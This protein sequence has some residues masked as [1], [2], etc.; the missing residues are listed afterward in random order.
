MKPRR[1]E[2][3]VQAVVVDLVQERPQ[4]E[5]HPLQVVVLV[6]WTS[7]ICLKRRKNKS[8]SENGNYQSPMN[9]SQN[10]KTESTR[11]KASMLALTVLLKVSYQLQKTWKLIL[12]TR[13]TLMN[14]VKFHLSA[15]AVIRLL[16]FRF[17]IKMICWNT[18]M[19]LSF[20]L[21]SWMILKISSPKKPSSLLS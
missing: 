6:T 12:K 3:L 15:S 21:K 16:V 10:M 9:R 5:A 20:W 11:I 7:K 8:G 18:K 19:Q 4:A 13:W 2:A 17:Q 14:I 1:T